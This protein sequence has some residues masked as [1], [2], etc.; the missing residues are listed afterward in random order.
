MRK[1]KTLNEQLYEKIRAWIIAEGE[2]FTGMITEVD[3]ARSYG[4]SIT[5]VHEALTRLCSEG[6]LTKYPKKG[7]LIKRLSQ[8]EYED[9]FDFRRSLEPSMVRYIIENAA[10]EDYAAL[11]ALAEII[12]Q[13]LDEEYDMDVRFHTALAHASGNKWYEQTMNTLFTALARFTAYRNFNVTHDNSHKKIV[14][15]LRAGNAEL[16][17]ELIYRNLGGFKS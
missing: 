9:L 11:E 6:F 5:P 17:S 14:E 4:A 13:T 3:I 16:A 7:Y 12:P 2:S 15:A 1:T 8:E 10:E